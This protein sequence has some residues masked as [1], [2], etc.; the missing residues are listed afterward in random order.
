MLDQNYPQGSLLFSSEQVRCAAFACFF[1]LVDG[2]KLRTQK[3]L[4][5]GRKGTQFI[6]EQQPRIMGLSTQVLIDE[7]TV[8]C[9]ASRCKG[10]NFVGIDHNDILQA[11]IAPVWFVP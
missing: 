6:I 2:C 8:D 11:R 5:T 3:G 4:H 9:P 1:L 10:S 7:G